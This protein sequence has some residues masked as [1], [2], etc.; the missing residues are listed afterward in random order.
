MCY[1]WTLLTTHVLALQL[2]S[3]FSGELDLDPA[4]DVCPWLSRK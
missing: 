1:I 2:V 4:H 3:S